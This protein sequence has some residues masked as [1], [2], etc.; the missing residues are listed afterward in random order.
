MTLRILVDYCMK[1]ESD[2][3]KPAADAYCVEKG[4]DEAM[5]F[6][7]RRSHLSFDYGPTFHVSFLLPSFGNLCPASWLTYI[8]I[9]AA[10]YCRC[11]LEHNICDTFD[12]ITCRVTKQTYYNPTEHGRALDGCYK[13]GLGCGQ[14]S[15]DAFCEDRGY[16]RAL[17]FG[18]VEEEEVET[19][20]MGDHAVCDPL[21]HDC[22]TFSFI[23]CIGPFEEPPSVDLLP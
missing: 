1:F 11:S 9:L 22:G 16:S 8:L 21:W 2:C 14:P 17:E 20:T 19:M 13:W 18:E 5:E 7:K 15:A 23:T 3:G 12:Y 10:N 4:C 6:P